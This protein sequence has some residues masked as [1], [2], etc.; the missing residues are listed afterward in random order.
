MT[1]N[2]YYKTLGVDKKA[3]PDEIKK[4][5]RKLALKYH[6][7]RNPNNKQAEEKFKEIN[8]AYA[9]LGDPEKRKQYDTVGSENFHQRYTQEDIF[10][11]F[12]VG[13]LFK[14][15]G[16]GSE[17]IFE[18]IFNQG[19]GG[20]RRGGFEQENIFSPQKQNGEDLTYTLS[21][22]LEEAARGG[23][24][25]VSY[26]MKNSTEEISV[27]IPPGINNGVKLRLSGKG[28]PALGRYGSPGDLYFVINIL[29]HP[30]F[31]REGNDLIV[32]KEIRFSEAVLGE[33]IEFNTLL[34]G[35]KK[36]KIKPGTKDGTKIRLKNLGMPHLNKTSRGNLILTLSIIVPQSINEKQKKLIEELGKEGL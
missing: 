8:E 24:K 13:D 3:N 4:I 9:V 5:Y 20:R 16:F 17:N 12:D 21:I 25:R 33:N 26:R 36:V 34:D 18:R 14:D 35:V 31:K 1:N 23:Q 7:D 32:H 22:T 11:G 29:E 30:G 28:L 15:F 27:K 2:D 10:R 6:P 19:G